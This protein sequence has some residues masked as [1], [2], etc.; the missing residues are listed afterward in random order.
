MPRELGQAKRADLTGH[1]VGEPSEQVSSLTRFLVAAAQLQPPPEDAGGGNGRPGTDTEV[2]GHQTAAPPRH[3]DTEV[4]PHPRGGNGQARD[5][6]HDTVFDSPLPTLD[7]SPEAMTPEPMEPELAPEPMGVAPVEA[8]P[9]G[10]RT[11]MLRP[12]PVAAPAQPLAPAPLL[13][14]EPEALDSIPDF[15]SPEHD[16]P[17]PEDED[18]EPVTDKLPPRSLVSV[19][20]LPDLPPPVSSADTG[21]L[22]MEAE[23]ISPAD[24]L[25]VEELRADE[26]THLQAGMDPSEKITSKVEPKR[27]IDP[28]SQDPNAVVRDTVNFYNQTQS[29]HGQRPT[30]KAGGE[31]VAGTVPL[32]PRP[33]E[34][35]DSPSR[36]FVPPPPLPA[37]PSL[38]A[39]S[40]ELPLAPSMDEDLAPQSVTAPSLTADD[41]IEDANRKDT[42]RF[43]EDDR[44]PPDLPKP[45]GIDAAVSVKTRPAPGQVPPLDAVA[46]EKVAAGKD[47]QK[48]FVAEILAKRDAAPQPA[49]ARMSSDSTGELQPET[50]RELPPADGH[51]TAF[52]IGTERQATVSET[53]AAPVL[54][55]ATE[56]EKDFDTGYFGKPEE[57]IIPEYDGVPDEAKGQPE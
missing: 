53:K 57:R 38:D 39:E 24:Q 13:A 4:A 12:P 41:E 36:R 10:A 27:D 8:P 7:L 54:P 29:L 55:E 49:P 31:T 32:A 19:T 17:A 14:S 26:D 20:P 22:T 46:P 5:T 2:A 33:R 50:A 40:E 21:M 37:A 16:A 28:R 56:V 6:V 25:T 18:A 23:T 34:F 11:E 1:F 44:R 35:E 43:L 47:T 3:H 9:L 51:D 30:P 52:E 48:F 42:D 15:A 45:T